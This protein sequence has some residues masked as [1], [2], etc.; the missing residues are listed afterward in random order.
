MTHRFASILFALCLALIVARPALAEEGP[1]V[2]YTGEL[3]DDQGRPLTGVFPITINLYDTA[4]ATAPRWSDGRWVSIVDGSYTVVL[5]EAAPLPAE[6][7]G[8]SLSIGVNIGRTGE[9]TRHD[10]VLA[11]SAPEPTRDE[12]IADL[13][14]S[15]AD[16]A[17]RAL[18]A[19]DA[20]QADDCL[21][22][23]G[24]TLDELDRFE[25]VL[26]VLAEI[27][28][29]VDE[30]D[31]PYVGSRTTTLERVGGSGGNGFTQMCPPNYVVVGMRGAAGSV[32]DSIQLIC[33][34]L[35]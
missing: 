25:E 16:L 4:D 5:G 12:I 9:I 22:I 14:V 19:E 29:D 33:A 34:P 32:V 26:G 20:A 15:F 8:R 23:G 21:M 10:I 13:D 27:R 30:I 7:L 24:R 1:F 31:G 3:I 28:D 2:T 18:Y 17:D 6:L 35:E 11:A